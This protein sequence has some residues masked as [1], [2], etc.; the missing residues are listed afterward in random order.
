MV[1]EQKNL[2]I[3]GAGGAGREVESWI[4]L[5]PENKR[6]VRIKGFLDD[7]P[8]A[9]DGY[10]CA[11]QIVGTPL[12]Y[13]Y[14]SDDCVVIAFTASLELRARL[15]WELKKRNVSFYTFVAPNAIVGQ[16]ACIE[17]GAIICPNCLISTNANIG[18]NVF[19][20]CGSQIGHDSNIGAH[21]AMM[22]RVDVGGNCEIGEQTYF[23][24]G[25]VISPGT[26]VCDKAQLSCGTVLTRSIRKP[27]TFFGNPA[28]QLK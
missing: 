12:D 17:E 1:P 3:I 2:L 20:N 8:N 4:Q 7:N 19:V 11:Y 21:T 22:A 6:D 25:S 16:N 27:A 24:T 23:G 18:P 13:S 26:Y 10:P 15:Y 9:L 14:Q 5:V 28:V